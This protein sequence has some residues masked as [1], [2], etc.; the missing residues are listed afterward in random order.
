MNR[1][2]GLAL[3]AGMLLCG[4]KSQCVLND[5]VRLFAGDAARDCGSATNADDRGDVD[6]CV[7]E[8]FEAGEP[9]IARYERAGVDSKVVTAVASNSDGRIKIFQW[10]SAPCGGPGC[11]PVTDVQG[12]SGPSLN[13]DVA[14]DPDALHARSGRDL[15]SR[16][17]PQHDPAHDGG[18][19]RDLVRRRLRLP[20][21]RGGP[22]QMADSRLSAK[23]HRLEHRHHGR[24]SL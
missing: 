3:A 6:A 15:P 10:D 17:H 13:P 12:C 4:C 11:D 18:P 8:A 23:E 24:A 9:F 14:E 1:R 7:A 16:R 5:D 20:V 19:P 22:R 21:S 2:V